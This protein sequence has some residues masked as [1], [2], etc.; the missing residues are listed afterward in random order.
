[1]TL[2]DEHEILHWGHT[3]QSMVWDKG[4]LIDTIE[5][6]FYT[7]AKE[8]KILPDE[9]KYAAIQWRLDWESAWGTKNVH[10]DW[11]QMII[12]SST[13][14]KLIAALVYGLET[15][16][17]KE[18]RPE[19]D[20]MLKLIKERL[21]QSITLGELADEVGLSADYLGRQFKAEVGTPFNE[22]VNRLR[23]EKAAYLLKHS[24]LKVYEIAERIGISNYRY[25]SIL[26]RKWAGNTPLEFKKGRA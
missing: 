4:R 5:H 10:G 11:L 6:R 7:W 23:M 1:M 18:V 9:L 3:F 2:R 26:F 13:L 22:Y 17:S 20:W 16:R 12:Q 8:K 14:D 25:F 24:S 21:N 15:S 19:I